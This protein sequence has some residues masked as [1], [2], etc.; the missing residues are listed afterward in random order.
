M[1]RKK[2]PKTAEIPHP[3]VTLGPIET[4]L[5]ASSASLPSDPFEEPLPDQSTPLPAQ[6]KNSQLKWS[7]EMIE[8]LVECIYKVWKDG[9]AADNGFKKDVWAEVSEA[10]MRVYK[11]SLVIG[12]DKCKNKWGDL[13]EKWKHWLIL[14]EMSGFGWSEEKERYEA[15]DYVW[16]N[17][18]KSYPRILWHKTHVMP[19]RDILSE[20]LHEAQ[21]TGKGA[22]SGDTLLLVDTQLLDNSISSDSAP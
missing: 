14:S 9:R 2:A 12:W 18:N 10:V 15:Y 17:L 13:K 4:E 19:Y 21:A 7:E 3:D 20:V 22:V 11:G 8:A 5:A 6:E 16:E 1:A